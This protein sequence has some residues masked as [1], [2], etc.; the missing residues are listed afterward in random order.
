MT[1]WYAIGLLIALAFLREYL[2][3]GR[4]RW[5]GVPPPKN[6]TCIHGV[7]WRAIYPCIAC[8]ELKDL[9]DQH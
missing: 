7:D 5:K 1:F 2:Y 8:K 4:G 9:H 3:N 6:C